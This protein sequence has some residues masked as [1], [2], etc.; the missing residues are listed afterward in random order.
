MAAGLRTGRTRPV[1]RPRDGA[2][3]DSGHWAEDLG[4]VDV[5]RSITPVAEFDGVTRARFEA[6]VVPAGRP[7]V[8]RGLLADWPAVR[9]SS[10]PDAFAEFLRP[11]ASAEPGELWV[12][13]PVHQGRFT[14]TDQLDDVTFERKLATVDQLLDLLLRLGEAA[15]PWSLYAGALQL[16]KHVPRFERD[17]SMPLLDP[18][19]ARLASLWLGNRSKTAAHWDL[20]QNL[21]CVVAERRRFTLFPTEQ[22][23]NLYVGPLDL[24]LAGQSSSLADIEAPDFARYPK[25]REA[26]EA[27]E[28]AELAP[29]DVL[30]MPSLWWHAVSTAGPLG[31]MV[32]YWWRDG[33]AEANTPLLALLH[34]VMLMRDLPD[35]E[36]ARWGTLFDH[37]A[38]ARDGDPAEHIPAAARG[39]LG[40][41]SAAE[42][43]VVRARLA[44]SLR[45]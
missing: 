31:A 8:F 39:I 25:L 17:H 34:A 44:R 35:A 32:N 2:E 33:P 28:V 4:R 22:V 11:L 27:A 6:E 40:T 16:D 3:L 5:S 42:L 13:E 30:Y 43:A 38:F 36:R 21:A 29:G 14:F 24:T 41:P 19:R 1:S 7:A 12:A 20:P 9:A 15:E 26:F 23:V 37:Y 10:T 18:S 45:D